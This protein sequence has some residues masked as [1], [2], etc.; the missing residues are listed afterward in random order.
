[1]HGQQTLTQELAALLV[2]AR[3]LGLRFDIGTAYI[4]RS[5][6]DH[7]TDLNRRIGETLAKLTADAG[8]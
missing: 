1:M 5:Y 8:K 7:Q 6:I 3:D 4:R 2:E